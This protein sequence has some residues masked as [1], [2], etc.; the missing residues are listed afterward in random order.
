MGSGRVLTQRDA[1]EVVVGL[2]SVEINAHKLVV[3]LVVDITVQDK[4]RDNARAPRRLH[5]GLDGAVP[6]VR[7]RRH[8][9]AHAVLR[10][11][12]EDVAVVLDGLALV[13]PVVLVRVAEV[14]VH[15]DYAVHAVHVVLL[16]LADGGRHARVERVGHARVA[17]AEAEGAGAALVVFLHGGQRERSGLR[18]RERETHAS[19]RGPTWGTSCR[20]RTKEA[21]PAPGRQQTRRPSRPEEGT[22]RA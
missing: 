21:A 3:N 5:L 11:R 1:L 9:G 22:W 18:R 12:Q 2:R 4:S 10:H 20:A 19:S 8:D 7:G 15:G 14:L 17:A 16:A 6:H 13:D